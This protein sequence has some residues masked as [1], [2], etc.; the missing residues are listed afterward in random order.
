MMGFIVTFSHMYVMYFD[1]YLPIALPCSPLTCSNALPLPN[2]P[3]DFHLCLS[4]SLFS[5]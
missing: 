5:L 4:L 3:F 2:Y 1:P